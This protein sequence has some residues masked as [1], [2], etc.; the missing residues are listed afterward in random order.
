M[1][2]FHIGAA[3]VGHTWMLCMLLRLPVVHREARM[4]KKCLQHLRYRGSKGWLTFY[5]FAMPNLLNSPA[6]LLMHGRD[7]FYPKPGTEVYQAAAMLS[8]FYG[9]GGPYGNEQYDPEPEPESEGEEPEPEEP[10]P[11]IIPYNRQLQTETVDEILQRA[12][13][14]DAR[15]RRMA[16]KQ[17]GAADGIDLRPPHELRLEGGIPAGDGEVRTDE[18]GD[19]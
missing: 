9:P 4:F 8:K 15:Q 13:S 11:T 2:W 5:R 12:D 16:L 18:A 14:E 17:D 10:K 1:N 6:V 7:A 19:R 3:V